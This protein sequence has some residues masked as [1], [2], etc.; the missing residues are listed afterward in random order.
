MDRF[1]HRVFYLLIA[2]N[3]FENA[4]KLVFLYHPYVKEEY[5]KSWANYIL[6]LFL[7]K[8][9]FYEAVLHY[10]G[11][12]Y[13]FKSIKYINL[14][15]S[16][17]KIA[18]R[19]YDEGY[20]E[21]ALKLYILLYAVGNNRDYVKAKIG[22][23]LSKK[24]PYKN[25]LDLKD[26]AYYNSFIFRIYSL[27]LYDDIKDLFHTISE[28]L[29]PS[30]KYFLYYLLARI[31]YDEGNYKKGLLYSEILS[32]SL[33]YI[34]FLPNNLLK[35]LYPVM[36]IEKIKEELSKYRWFLDECFIMSII[37]EESRY[38]K[39]ALSNQ[40]AV[41]LMQ[42][43]PDTATWIYNEKI[44]KRKLLNPD[45]NIEV[46]IKFLNYLYNR[47]TDCCLI[48]ASYN[49]G[50]TNVLK[51]MNKYGNDNVDKFIEVIPY[52]ETRNFV[53]KVYTTYSLYKETYPNLCNK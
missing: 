29:D 26:I 6:G 46:G 28:T 5:Y 21:K 24:Y 33:N 52:S 42:I 16:R 39:M 27:G 12:F 35:M 10:P 1:V 51:W 17:L 32:N 9:Y 22:N 3:Q 48:L 34:I 23:I 15:K 37:R 19:F 31:Y 20:Y 44:S 36:Y 38:D 43:M 47:F 25:L 40:G 14:P 11:S 49:G 4:I 2:D 30:E 13:Y 8:S 50:P 45:F 53:K 7:D 41:G 18:D